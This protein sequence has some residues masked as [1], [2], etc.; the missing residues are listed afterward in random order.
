MDHRPSQHSTTIQWPAIPGNQN[1]LQKMAQQR[2]P[3]QHQ[4]APY[5]F[6]SSAASPSLSQFSCSSMHLQPFTSP[7]SQLTCP[8]FTR[9]HTQWTLNTHQSL[10]PPTTE[11][12]TTTNHPW[13]T[14]KKRKRTYPSTET[15]IRGHLSPFNSPNQFEQLSHLSDDDIQNLPLILTQQ[16]IANKSYSRVY[17]NRPRYMFTVLQIVVTW[18]NTLQKT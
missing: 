3:S 10:D 12:E 8:S 6:S 5:R 1:Q 15:A 9:H 18:W 13:Q 11:S 16:Q 7:R 2:P 14:V 17:T 4:I